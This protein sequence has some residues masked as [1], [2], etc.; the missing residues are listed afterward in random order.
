MKRSRVV[1]GIVLALAVAGCEG[2]STV[3]PAKCGPT[4][5]K[6]GC[7]DKSGK[8][9]EGNT[10]YSCGAGGGS[11]KACTTG[12]LC[13]D[14]L[15]V[16]AG[17]D[18]SNCSGCCQA[19]QCLSGTT[20]SA[21]GV[22]GIPC[23][24]C[25]TDQT[26]LSGACAA[27]QV[28]DATT[29]AHGCCYAASGGK[30]VCMPGTNGAVCGKGGA[31]CK[32]CA[33][34]Q[35]CESQECKAQAGC[36]A[37]SCPTGCCYNGQCMPGNNTGLCGKGGAQCQA[38]TTSQQCVN[39]ACVAVQCNATTCPSG[40]CDAGGACQPG[41][42]QSACGA[43]GATCVQC[44]AQQFCNAS[45]KCETLPTTACGPSNC[46]GCCDGTGKCQTG[47]TNTACGTSGGLCKSCGT[48]QACS[49]GKCTCTSSSCSA[50]C[51]QG[52]NCQPG[53][54]DTACGKSG[55]VC[56]VCSGTAKCV[57][58]SCSTA[59]GPTTCVGCCLSGV[60]KGGSDPTACGKGGATC[61]VCK[62]GESC[63]NGTC[64]SSSTCSSSN[65]PNGCCASGVCQAGTSDTQC[66]KGG[67]VCTNCD[68]YEICSSQACTLDKAFLWWVYLAEVK[69][70]STKDWDGAGDPPDVYVVV[71][72]GTKSHTTK[73]IDNS[74]NPV[75]N[76]YLF[77]ASANELTTELRF[78]IY[79]DD[80]ILFDDLICDHKDIVLTSEILNRSVTYTW[81]CTDNV[82]SVKF[83]FY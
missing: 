61:A 62:A 28:C 20:E 70:V 77:D 11:C 82:V 68:F 78:K 3:P 44:T 1:L 51:C 63:V 14:G 13:Q 16:K 22:G 37:T 58:G 45:K 5:C 9:V 79:D 57:S 27:Q 47:N 21:C 49:G 39:Q 18:T 35:K 30:G 66:G 43:A 56:T 48:N 32:E 74:W 60:C 10:E 81:A 72:T 23:A 40:C 59:C 2:G 41:T 75:Y 34:N 24:T 7:C 15:C 73:T 83:N 29:C 17:C 19:D 76:E 46:N 36:D 33:A 67:A 64:N 50:G 65:C 38:C 80:G 42:G 25:Q 31:P 69:L 54:L 4:T 71:T 52:D 6:S 55:G 12:S 8:C 53:T 26:C